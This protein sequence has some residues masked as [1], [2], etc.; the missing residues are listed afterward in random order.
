MNDLEIRKTIDIFKGA[1]GFVEVRIIGN[2]TYSGYFKN[3]DVLL[4]ELKKFNGKSQFYFVFN[5][6]KDACYSREQCEK[7]V[8]RAKQTTSDN[9]IARRRWVL[10]DLDPRRASGV[11]STAEEKNFARDKANKIY[12]FLKDIGF[13]EPVCCDSGNGY[14]LLYNVDMANKDEE[15]T[16][17]KTFLEAIDVLFTDDNVDVD[18]SVFNASRITK[19]YGTTAK[20]GTNTKER[21]YRDSKI[22]R[23]PDD[24]KP[25]SKVLFEKVCQLVPKPEKPTYKNNYNTEQFDLDKFIA[26]NNIRVK[27]VVSYGG[28]KKYVLEE[29][30]FD[31]NHKAPDACIFQLQ[32]GAIGYHCFHSSC[33]SYTWKDVR[34]MFEP[35]AYD[36]KREFEN[37]RATKPMKKVDIN[38]IKPQEQ[39]A[40]KGKKFLHL[41]DIENIDR[42]KIVSIPTGIRELDKKIIGLNKGETTLWS[43]KNSSGK[44]A[45]LNQVMLNAVDKGFRI[46]IFSGELTP[47]RLK[48]WIWLQSAGRQ[49]TKPTQYENAFYVPKETGE[50][51]DKWCADKIEIYNNEY[52]NDF[53]QI[54]ADFKEVI[55]DNNIDMVIMDNLMSLNL[56]M[57]SGDKLQQQTEFILKI[58]EM[59]HQYNVAVNVVCHPRKSMPNMFLRK[60]DISGSADLTNAVENVFIVHRVNRDFIKSAKE[61]FGEQEVEK[62]KDFGN[63]IEV[64]KNRDLGVQDYMVGLYYENESKRFLNE[65]FENLNYGWQDK[66]VEL[67][68]LTEAELED[69][70]G[71]SD[72]F[73]S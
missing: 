61:F 57:F 47:N 73:R 20:K 22:I 2:K 40:E 63:V 54:L 68:P 12:S 70:F 13:S 10:I 42:S 52:G 58:V 43:G 36:K 5:S 15:K 34:K 32:N 38:E 14:H 6:I 41:S 55:K 25:T 48:Q 7:F 30:V 18:T 65:K 16:L 27:N 21:P 37:Y 39:V 3:V 4:K 46:A 64:C 66:P 53:A 9:D 31:S 33:S 60:E 8:E 26:K 71:E 51:I 24:I 67:I 29:C 35:D 19:L 49:Y 44:S 17:V 72:P 59:A 11:G 62:Y 56:S 23:V 69:I 1:D 28:V 50:K 45:V